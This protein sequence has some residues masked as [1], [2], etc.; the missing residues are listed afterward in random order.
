MQWNTCADKQ[1]IEAWQLSGFSN[2]LFIVKILESDYL[3]LDLSIYSSLYDRYVLFICNPRIEIQGIKYYEKVKLLCDSWVLDVKKGYQFLEHRA[4]DANCQDQAAAM[5]T[6]LK[7]S[8]Q[9]GKYIKNT[10]SW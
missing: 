1:E 5:H 10:V 8:L 7:L 9:P 4:T 6:A 2:N 3:A